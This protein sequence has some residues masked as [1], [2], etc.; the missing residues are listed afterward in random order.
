MA[1]RQPAV[2]V[3]HCCP[4]CNMIVAYRSPFEKIKCAGCGV[5]AVPDPRFKPP[6]TMS[7]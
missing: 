2:L 3:G 1:K 6:R 4:K 5:E 7:S